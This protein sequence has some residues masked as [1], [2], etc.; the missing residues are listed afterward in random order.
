MITSVVRRAP[1]RLAERGTPLEMASTPVTAA[2]GEGVQDHEQRGAHEQAAAAAAEVDQ[3]LLR[4]LGDGQVAGGHPGET[5]AQ[6]QNH[7]GDEEVGGRGEEPPRLLDAAV[8]EGDQTD[9]RHRERH[10]EGR[11][12]GEGR[13]Q[14]GDAGGHR[15]GHG[16]DIVG[17]ECD[18]GDLGGQMPKLSRVT[19]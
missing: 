16:Q 19:M 9:E 18:P 1:G 5:Q 15:H 2:G 14:G 4:V 11:E 10:G 12:P 17:Q 3:A 6:Q 13:G 7:V 8:A